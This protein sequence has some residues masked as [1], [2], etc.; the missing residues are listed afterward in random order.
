MVEP[1]KVYDL[2]GHPEALQ[3]ETPMDVNR[4]PRRVQELA[5]DW[6]AR[7]RGGGRQV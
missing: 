5:F 2:L 1:R 7:Q 4:F 3:F 6:L